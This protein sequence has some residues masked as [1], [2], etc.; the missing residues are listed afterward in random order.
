M[1]PSNLVWDS[2]AD[3][4]V[5]VPSSLCGAIVHEL[6]D[7]TS[8]SALALDPLLFTWSTS[9]NTETLSAITNDLSK[10]GT[11]FLR[12]KVYYQDFAATTAQ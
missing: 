9:G 1:G 4:T 3:I 5:D 7:V 10:E 12:F 11:Y 6:Y 8:G 2:T